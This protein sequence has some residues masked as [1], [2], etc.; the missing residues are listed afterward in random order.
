MKILAVIRKSLIEQSRQVWLILL[1]VLMAPFFVGIYYFMWETTQLTLTVSVVDQDIPVGNTGY[2]T[3][4]LHWMESKQTDSLP[5]HFRNAE[6]RSAALLDLEK[7]QAE[8]ILIIPSDFSSKIMA[9][10][11]GESVKVPFE[12]SGDM[13]DPNYMLAAILAHQYLIT[14][15]QETSDAEL[16]YEFK[17]TPAGLSGSMKEFDLY[18]PGLLILSTIMLMFTGAIAFVRESEQ[19]TI[20]RLKLSPLKNY[21]LI[22]GI[23]FIQILIG[24]IS[25]LATLF[26]AVLLGF[27]FSGSWGLLLLISILVCLSVIG[28]SLILASVTKTMNQI[29]IA[30]NFPLFL[31][32]FF[33]GIMLPVHGPT[34]FRFLDYDFTLPG[35]MSPYHAVEAIR[36]V[37]LFKAGFMDILPE[38]ISLIGLTIIYFLIGSFL[39]RRKHLRL[40]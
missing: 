23:T 33:T 40:E 18:V 12:L 19:G 20:L 17:E 32:M 4:F 27:S 28:F 25:I 36:K 9:L 16:F 30:G 3:N 37:S 39:F 24:L 14:Y 38:L 31:F 11:N 29:L 7:K 34:I 35:L 22:G 26:L 2:G 15:I 13:S 5:V 8:A 1:T 6:S 10:K 21:E